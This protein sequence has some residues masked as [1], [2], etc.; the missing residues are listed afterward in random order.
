MTLE[1]VTKNYYSIIQGDTPI[2]VTPGYVQAAGFYAINAESPYVEEICKIVDIAFATEE[3]QEGTGLCGL[4]FN[5]GPVG[6]NFIILDDKTYKIQ[7]ADGS[8]INSADLGKVAFYGYSGYNYNTRIAAGDTNLAARSRAWRDNVIPYAVG[9]RMPSL[10][11]YLKPT[12]DEMVVY[13]EY[14]VGL[15]SYFEEMRDKFIMGLE[16]VNDD[17]VWEKYCQG[18][19]DAGL[20]E[21]L[22]VYQAAYERYNAN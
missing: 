19:K 5:Y 12:D 7:N 2:C 8:D 13:E 15:K 4:A 6:V 1:R 20:E 22:E 16:D 10:E 11:Y 17:A 21:L 3:V 9:K 14:Y 18:M